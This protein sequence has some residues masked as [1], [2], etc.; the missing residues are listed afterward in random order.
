MERS[1]KEVHLTRIKMRESTPDPKLTVSCPAG[2]HLRGDRRFVG[3]TIKCPRCQI[4]F[5]FAPTS[6]TESRDSSPVVPAL[7][8]RAITDT[9]VMR[10]LETEDRGATADASAKNLR[11]CQRCGNAVA[12]GEVVCHHCNGYVGVLPAFMQRLRDRGS[13][14]AN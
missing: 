12:E 13:V 3:R 14:Q 5:V 7:T 1:E 4:Q 6:T 9:G 8:D 11:P 2:H 10:I